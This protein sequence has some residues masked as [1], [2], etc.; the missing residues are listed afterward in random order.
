MVKPINWVAFNE[1][2]STHIVEY[3]EEIIGVIRA[4]VGTEAVLLHPKLY[5]PTSSKF[6]AFKKEF[7]LFLEYLKTKYHYKYWYSL[8]K[9][10]K[11]VNMMTDGK[12]YPIT[13][14]MGHTLYEC[15]I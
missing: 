7:Y 1:L 2:Q 9:N 15:E 13:S 14:I 3:N 12:A 6:K 8:T 4:E 5:T 10:V 11:L